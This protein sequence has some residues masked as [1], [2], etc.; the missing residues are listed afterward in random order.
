MG[1]FLI[2]GFNFGV[3]AARTAAIVKDGTL[4]LRLVGEESVVA[5]LMAS[6]NHVWNWLIQPPFL[7]AIGVP[8][9]VSP[10]GDFDHEITEQELDDYDIAMYIME[11]HDVLPCRISRSGHVV[12]TTGK[13]HA[14]REVW[15]F[16]AKF[17]VP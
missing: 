13:V 11:H 2:N 14:F 10:N 5:D 4:D 3:D 7:Y 15:D 12:R 17:E 16:D 9:R 6:D 1:H 8:C